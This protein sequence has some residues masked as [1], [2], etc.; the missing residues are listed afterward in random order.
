[1]IPNDEIDRMT[2][3]YNYFALVRLKAGATA[4]QA[5]SEMNVVQARF[6]K[7]SGV[8]TDL[9]AVLIPVH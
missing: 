5:L 7:P 3:N 6:P 9:K 4:G 8:T 2:G 1:V